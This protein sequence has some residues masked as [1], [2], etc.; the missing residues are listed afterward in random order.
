MDHLSSLVLVLA[1]NLTY[2][3]VNLPNKSG[4]ADPVVQVLISVMQMLIGLV[5]I[6]AV[7]AFVISGIFYLTSAGDENRME[8]GKRG[9]I[10]AVLGL[11]V[12]L[13]S[14]IILTAIYNWMVGEKSAF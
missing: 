9:M 8:Q 14:F 10:Y 4:A 6:L 13:A 1:T 12:A 2:P 5:G 11:V 3:Q 7:V